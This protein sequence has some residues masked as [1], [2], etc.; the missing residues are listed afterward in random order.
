MCFRK[1]L[2]LINKKGNGS[3]YSRIDPHETRRQENVLSAASGNVIT[4]QHISDPIEHAWIAKMK[5]HVPLIK[6][7]RGM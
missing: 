7:R 2:S 5:Q 3:S 6:H 1:N 4:R